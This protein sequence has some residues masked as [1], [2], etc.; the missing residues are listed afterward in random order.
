M[1]DTDARAVSTAVG[2]VLVLGIATLLV[3]GLLFAGSDFVADQREETLRNELRVLGQQVADDLA[4]ADRLVRA[5]DGRTAVT[6]T[7]D[8]PETATGSSYSV[9]VVPNGGSPTT[10]V[11]TSAD[12]EVTV[13]VTVRVETAVD[14]TTVTGGRIAIDYTGSALEVQSG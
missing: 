3:T 7:R 8:L 6:V 14:A 2:Y 10:I 1:T 11:L 4:A 9:E 13:E 12:P 5:S